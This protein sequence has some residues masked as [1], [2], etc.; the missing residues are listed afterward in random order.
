M[1]TGVEAIG[2]ANPVRAVRVLV[3]LSAI[4]RQKRHKEILTPELRFD[5]LPEP[6]VATLGSSRE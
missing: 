4:H 3:L 5:D 6:A 2:G 1:L